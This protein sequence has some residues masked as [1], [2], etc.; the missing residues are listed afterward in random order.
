[1]SLA[2]SISNRKKGN[3]AFQQ[4]SYQNRTSGRHIPPIFFPYQLYSTK[5]PCR[6]Y[7][8]YDRSYDRR[9][10]YNHDHKVFLQTT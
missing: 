5:L 8:D 7:Q 9:H 1:M 6:G 2:V 10:L 4:T 3:Y